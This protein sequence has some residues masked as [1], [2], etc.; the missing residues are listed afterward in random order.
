MEVPHLSVPHEAAL[1]RLRR[2]ASDSSTAPALASRALI[3]LCET[4]RLDDAAIFALDSASLLFTA[5]LAYSGPNAAELVHWLRDVYL[6]S[7]PSE[8]EGMTFPALLR[9]HGGVWAS[10]EDVSRWIG[11][12]PRP[13]D[14][15][16]FAERWRSLGSPPG[17][18]VRLGLGYR[19]RWV[20]ALQGA[21]WQPGDGLRPSEV[22][23]LRRAAPILGKALVQMLHNREA[24]S[25]RPAVPPP[26]H[27]LFDPARQLAFLDASAEAWLER[28][29]H[30]SRIEGLQA[31][32]PVQ[33]AVAYAQRYPGKAIQVSLADR[34]G[35]PIAVRGEPAR[36]ADD[37]AHAGPP[38]IHVSVAL[39]GG[40]QLGPGAFTPRQLDVARGIAR[41]LGDAAIAEMLGIGRGTVHQHVRALHRSAGT[42]RRAELTLAVAGFDRL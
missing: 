37:S 40:T 2:I 33:A 11:A 1:T 4:V 5:L 30:G 38:W 26:G 22:E 9:D 18:G 12:V 14:P 6:G 13:A 10:H 7:E 25:N 17:G 36:R 16:L 24:R 42:H 39:A 15:A 3:V 28:F 31:P 20:A 8:P 21:R 41:G 19:G 27:F 29:P 32:L 34:Y 23:L 35:V